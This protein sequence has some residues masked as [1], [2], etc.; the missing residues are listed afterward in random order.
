MAGEILK[1]GS[2]KVPMRGGRWG[3]TEPH[4]GSKTYR[5]LANRL[6]DG[7][8]SSGTLRASGL[9]P[10]EGASRGTSHRCS[11]A[12]G[13]LV[14][15]KLHFD[16]SSKVIFANLSPRRIRSDSQRRFLYRYYFSRVARGPFGS[17]TAKPL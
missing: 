11:A 14:S 9:N 2:G 4:S 3:R 5:E 8:E 16:R 17:P 15:L 7:F 6:T 1:T 12:R 10:G 13:G